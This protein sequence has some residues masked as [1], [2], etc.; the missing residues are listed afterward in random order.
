MVNCQLDKA[1][2][3]ARITQQIGYV[4][5]QFQELEGV[6]AQYYVLLAEASLGMGYSDGMALVAEAKKRTFGATIRQLAKADLICG[7]TAA[8]FGELL[9]E[10]NWLV[11]RSRS[12][13]RSAIHSDKDMEELVSRLGSMG[14][15]A[16]SLLKTIGSLIEAHVRNHG[17]SQE[18]IEKATESLLAE[19][20]RS[21]SL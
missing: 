12:E 18:T 16:L 3:L 20:H 5:W 7:E 17:L 8:S 11:H 6:S 19:W 2:R 10:R 21:E 1:D 14:E 15:R 13:S 4:L 9:V